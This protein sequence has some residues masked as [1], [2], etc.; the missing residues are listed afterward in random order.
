MTKKSPKTAGGPSRTRQGR[1]A[2]RAAPKS[3]ARARRSAVPKP[4]VPPNLVADSGPVPIIVGIGASAGGLEA[5]T[6][7]LRSLPANANLAVVFVQHLAPQ[8]ESALVTLLT[9]Q[10][11]L[12]VVQAD[13]GMR[14]ELNHVYVIPPK[15][16]LVVSGRTLHVSRRPADRSQYNPIDAFF[17]SLAQAAGTRAVGVVLSGTA[18]DGSVGIRDIKMAGGL[19]IAQTPQSAKYDGMPRAA[20]ATNAIDLVLPPEQIGPKLAQFAHR[21]SLTVV[22][23]SDVAPEVRLS[24]EQLHELLDLLRPISGI[25][26][27]HYKPPTIKRRLFRRMGLRR[28]TDVDDYIRL[29]R[30]DAAEVRDLLIHVTRFFR[31]PDSFDALA[32]EVF[33]GIL[34][35]RAGD[36]PL[37]LAEA[38]LQNGSDPAALLDSALRLRSSNRRFTELFRLPGEGSRGRAL[39]DIAQAG[40][41]VERLAVEGDGVSTP[42]EAVLTLRPLHQQREIVFRARTFHT[43]DGSSNRLVL[44]TLAANPG[45]AAATE[46]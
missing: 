17:T 31:E 18:S 6:G 34:L 15:R 11:V 44:L 35:E 4:A 28:V 22:S 25:D 2:T 7:V 46:S 13:D 38:L 45:A 12:P 9:A 20:I 16:Q 24:D 21:A 36:Q 37:D 33:P 29:L 26:F 3:A 41:G 1:P 10:S 30:S 42:R 5:F 19:T 23:Q 14:V 40:K 43:Q 39:T 8:H 32:Q 27:R